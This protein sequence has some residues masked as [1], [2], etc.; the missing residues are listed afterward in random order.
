MAWRNLLL[1][2]P[3][4]KNGWDKTAQQGGDNVQWMSMYEVDSFV[5]SDMWKRLQDVLSYASNE[6]AWYPYDVAVNY[7]KSHDHTRIHPDSAPHEVEFTLLLYLS[8]GFAPGDYGETNWVLAREDDGVHSYIGPGGDMFESIGAVA[9]KFGRL[10]VFRNNIEH[11]A[12]PP[13]LQYLGGRFTFAVK[14]S[15]NKRLNL[16]KR[17]YERMEQLHNMSPTMQNY[18][19]QLLMGLHDDTDKSK[20]S[21]EDLEK[22]FKK[23]VNQVQNDR[24]D[25]HYNL[26]QQITRNI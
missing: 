17:T 15:R 2:R 12:H 23:V 26:I 16:V 25:E 18:N 22:V 24:A 5:L 13:S 19:R 10:A 8:E 3:I 4:T 9:P 14:V 6:T 20:L 7:L 1:P 11:S 21:T